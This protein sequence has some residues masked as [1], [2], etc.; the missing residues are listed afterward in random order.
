MLHQIREKWFLFIVAICLFGASIEGGNERLRGMAKEVT[1]SRQ[2]KLNFPTL[3]I[4]V[5][6]VKLAC[7]FQF[8]LTKR[9]IIL[10][11]ND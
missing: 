9:V 5:A 6:K 4:Q 10:K 3:S 7:S 8:S 2:Q 11:R 1:S